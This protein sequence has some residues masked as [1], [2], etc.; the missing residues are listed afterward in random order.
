MKQIIKIKLDPG[1]I[2]PTV[3]HET[4]A[5]MI[6]TLPPVIKSAKLLLCRLFLRRLCVPKYSPKRNAE[7]MVSGARA[8]EYRK[9]G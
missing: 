9:F 7:T 1:A 5:G 2:M 6:I 3:A 8:N 4:D